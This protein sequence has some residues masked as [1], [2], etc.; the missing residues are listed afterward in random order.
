M[1][2]KKAIAILFATVWGLTAT[3]AYFVGRG[4]R[5][6]GDHAGAPSSTERR[7]SPLS[8]MGKSTGFGSEGTNATA[9]RLA[10]SSTR[11]SDPVRSL[12][13]FAELGRD[14][15]LPMSLREIAST[16]DLE[17]IEEALD[18]LGNLA[19][20]LSQERAFREV[21]GRWAKLEPNNAFAFAADIDEPKRRYDSKLKVL[22]SWGEGDPA[23]ALAFLAENP[24]SS[25]TRYA[26]GAVFDGLAKGDIQVALAFFESIN[27]KD[28][29]YGGATYSAVRNLFERN[30]RKVIA[31]AEGLPEGE[32]RGRAID[33]VIDQWARYDP[34]AA[35]A[36]MEKNATG[37]ALPSA[38]IE[39]GESWARVDPEAAIAWAAEVEADPRTTARIKERIFSRWMQY[40]YESAANF[41]VEQEPSPQLDR[42]FEMYIAKARHY[43]PEATMAW[44]ESITD[45]KR[46]VRAIHSVAAV[47]KS[48][49][50]AAYKGYLQN[51]GLD[52]KSA[53]KLR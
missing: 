35:K 39:L 22:Q 34:V 11:S 2:S 10:S 47:W 13:T 46:R 36:W 14:A 26:E 32:V 5:D 7:D 51:A 20:S 33:G 1:R 53:K 24:D 31:W 38:Q 37:E 29:P 49:D 9:V 16:M 23:G 42:A 28:T 25:I 3:A 17:Q 52:K 15:A 40:D 43:D 50:N 48:R 12:L 21:I 8:G 18:A 44:A 45:P 41:L 4:H 19:P 27:E 6:A 30:D